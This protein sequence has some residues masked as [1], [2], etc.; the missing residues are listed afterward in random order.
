MNINKIVELTMELM[1]VSNEYG[2]NWS[3]GKIASII[4]YIM[5]YNETIPEGEGEYT[6]DMWLEDTELNNPEFLTEWW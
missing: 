5:E 2:V 4:E 1:E 3:Q 6:V